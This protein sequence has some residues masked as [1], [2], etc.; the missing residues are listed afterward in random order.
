MRGD[1]GFAT[2]ARKA[3]SQ[4]LRRRRAGVQIIGQG[5]RPD[6]VVMHCSKGIFH[7][8]LAPL[9]CCATEML[10]AIHL[11]EETVAENPRG[12][13]MS[14]GQQAPRH[15]FANQHSSI[16]QVESAQGKKYR[17]GMARRVAID[18]LSATFHNHTYIYI[19]VFFGSI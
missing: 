13:P 19:W 12:E 9:L 8:M 5:W 7:S 15:L 2:E 18:Q 3:L 17:S 11:T 14:C 10:C 6:G 16:H 1:V 4:L